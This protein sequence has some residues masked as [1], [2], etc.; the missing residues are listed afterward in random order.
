MGNVADV[1]GA[2][3]WDPALKYNEHIDFFIRLKRAK[4]KVL[5]CY[6]VK[7]NFISIYSNWI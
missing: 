4:L 5:N 7:V 1:R 3:G 6:S 2:G